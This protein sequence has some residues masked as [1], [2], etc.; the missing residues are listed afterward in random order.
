MG[1][2]AGKKHGRGN[3]AFPLRKQSQQE[4]LMIPPPRW[5]EPCNSKNEMHAS[6]KLLGEGGRSFAPSLGISLRHLTWR[7]E[8]FAH[9]GAAPAT[10]ERSPLLQLAPG[11]ARLQ[12]RSRTAKPVRGAARGDFLFAGATWGE[13]RRCL[14]EGRSGGAATSSIPAGLIAG[15]SCLFRAGRPGRRQVAAAGHQTES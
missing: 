8:M 5:S 6:F 2:K 1:A 15:R 3:S 11:P 9:A 4:E 14:R 12:L 13:R 7:E 10:W